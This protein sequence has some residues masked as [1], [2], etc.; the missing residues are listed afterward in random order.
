MVG[1]N[2]QDIPFSRFAERL[3]DVADA[4]H[5]VSGDPGERDVGTQSRV[6]SSEP[7]GRAWSRTRVSIGT[8]A[9]MRALSL[10]Q[11]LG[12]DSTRSIKA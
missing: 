12:R 8:W 10:V 1:A 3:L 2:A 5:A 6:R 7:P 11:A 9:S 4:V